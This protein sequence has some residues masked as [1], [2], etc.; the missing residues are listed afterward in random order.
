MGYVFP[1]RGYTGTV[2]LHWNSHP[3]G[4]DLFAREGTAVLAMHD[5]KVLYAGYDQ[6]GGNN[7]LIQGDDGLKSYYAHLWRAPSVLTGQRVT[8]G[9]QIG[10]VGDTGNAT[11]AGPHLHVGMG[12]S[13]INGTGP[14]GG[15]GTNFNLTN[16]LRSLLT[17]A[18]P[19][20]P[21]FKVDAQGLRLRVS[22]GTTEA[23]TVLA[24]LANGTLLE[25]TVNDSHSWRR[26]KVISGEHAGKIGWVADDGTFI[27]EA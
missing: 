24:E 8:M 19:S 1:V 26:V 21:R 5:G 2:A 3:G 25:G 15:C 22:P 23:A 17:P 6:Y 7:V 20:K 13:I 14:A 12:Q 9:Q 16:L 4:A 11:D 18:A 10:G 27:V